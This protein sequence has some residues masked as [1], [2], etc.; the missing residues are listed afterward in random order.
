MKKKTKCNE[1]PTTESILSAMRDAIK[2]RDELISK[3]VYENIK[4]KEENDRAWAF[5]QLNVWVRN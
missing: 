4:L 1:E 3:F 5:L 2:E